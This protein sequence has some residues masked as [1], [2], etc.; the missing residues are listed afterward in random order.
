MGIKAWPQHLLISS[1]ITANLLKG[2][3]VAFAAPVFILVVVAL[4]A[5]FYASASTLMQKDEAQN[6]DKKSE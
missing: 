6:L 4:L 1:F 5:N 2:L 3:N